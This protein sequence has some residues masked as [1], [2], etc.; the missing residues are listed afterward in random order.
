VNAETRRPLSTGPSLGYQAYSAVRDMITEG[1]LSAG[2]RVTERGLAALLG[3]SPTPVR[4]AI[5]RLIHERLLVR[6]D[7]RALE[8]TVPSF[9]RLYE[10]SLLQAAL[11]G[12]AARLAAEFATDEELADIARVHAES[13]QETR[14]PAEDAL[15]DADSIQRRHG[16]HQMIVAASHAPSVIDMLATAEA[17][18][19]ALRDRAQRS[20]AAENIIRA[21]V[22]EHQAILDA[23]LARDGDRAEALMREHTLWINRLYLQFAEED[24]QAATSSSVPGRR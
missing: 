5:T 10:A 13:L 20:G 21:A 19:R 3:V 8:V 24:G 2:E 15:A 12:V 18:G 14:R 17:F 16:F 9:R 7:G 22:E 6:I 1:E 11:R 23:L 4:E